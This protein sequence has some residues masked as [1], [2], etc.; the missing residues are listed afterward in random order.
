MPC[1]DSQGHLSE[2]ARNIL[3]ALAQPRTAEEVAAA[4][5]LPLYRVRS[6]VREMLEA[7][8]IGKQNGAFAI[9]PRGQE[10]TAAAKPA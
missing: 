7:G 9:T 4:L 1:I 6:G 2:A 10:L 3:A 5:N 8:L